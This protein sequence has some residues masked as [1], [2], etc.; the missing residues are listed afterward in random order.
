MNKKRF[1]ALILA[2]V[3]F[4]QG[5]GTAFARENT[6]ENAAYEDSEL[7][8]EDF[9]EDATEHEFDVSENNSETSD[10]EISDNEISDEIP[11]ENQNEL[12]EDIIE[13]DSEL[14]EESTDS[15]PKDS[16]DEQN[17]RA[18]GSEPS[19]KVPTMGATGYRPEP[20]PLK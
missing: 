19:D 8:S 3:L 2:G 6:E 15:D 17:D 16:E 20:T 13:E 1:L 4:A 7:L 11:D 12:L 18:M 5:A 10:N 9:L 14:L